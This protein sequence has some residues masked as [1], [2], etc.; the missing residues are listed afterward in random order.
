MKIVVNL[1][2]AIGAAMLA[3]GRLLAAPWF[4]AAVIGI[5]VWVLL[6]LYGPFPAITTAP[7]IKFLSVAEVTAYNTYAAAKQAGTW[8]EKAT[9]PPI[10]R[11]DIQVVV[12]TGING[13]NIMA[14]SMIGVVAA[15]IGS[16]G[17]S[18]MAKGIAAN[19]PDQPVARRREAEV[20]GRGSADYA[21]RQEAAYDGAP[22]R[23]AQER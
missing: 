18:A 8:D 3:L 21:P 13:R 20:N 2:N 14:A 7:S 15:I 17:I 11:Q 4:T 10:P 22:Q 6:G 19:K 16:F 23:S 12:F 1:S 5:G 9:P